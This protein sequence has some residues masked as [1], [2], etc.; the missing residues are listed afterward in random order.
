MFQPHPKGW[1]LIR[2]VEFLDGGLDGICPG[3]VNS[4]WMEGE[5]QFQV[6]E[7]FR[8]WRKGCLRSRFRSSGLAKASPNLIFTAKPRG[9]KYLLRMVLGFKWGS[10]C[11]LRSYLEPLGNGSNPKGG[12]QSKT[13][14]QEGG[15]GT[16]SESK[17]YPL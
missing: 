12:I 3:L 17:R 10:K 13:E 4:R 11:I 6:D 5:S 15:K 8:V 2:P 16:P 14:L 9:S 1:S 7:L